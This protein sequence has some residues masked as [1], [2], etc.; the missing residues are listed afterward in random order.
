MKVSNL[1]CVGPEGLTFA[2]DDI[3]CLVGP[4]NTGKSTVLRAYELAAAKA[5]FTEN[6]LCKRAGDSPASVELW[7]HIPAGTPNIAEKWKAPE[8]DLLLVRSKW[9][10]RRE[11]AWKAVRTTWDPEADDWAEDTNA[12]GLD[13]VFTSRLPVP[14]RVGTLQ[15]PEEEHKALLALVLQPVAERLR[16]LQR[17]TESD[18]KR[19]LDAFVTFAEKPVQ[20]EREKIKSLKEDLNRSHSQIFPHLA[21]D[22]DIGL[23]KLEIDLTAQLTK[24]S[25][26][27]F[28][29]WSDEVRWN[30]QGTG[31]QRALFWALLQVRSRL[32]TA[33]ELKVGREKTI[34][35][36]KKKIAKLEK[37]KKAAKKAETKV[38]K[39]EEIRKLQEQLTG[40]EADTSEP[41]TATAPSSLTLPGYMLLV[42]EPEVGLHPAAIRAASRYLYAL[43]EDPAWQVILSSHAPSFIDPLQD[44]TTIV[45]LSR[46]EA[47]PT[48]HTYRAAEVTFSA[49]ERENL[50]ILNRFDS[51]VAEMFF[52]QYPLL[53]EGDTEFASFEWTMNRPAGGWPMAGR[54]L[55]VRARGKQTLVLLIRML[56]HFKVPFSV[57][58]DSDTPYRRDG[59][60]NSAW[61]ANA[62]LVQEIS[63]ARKAGIRVV[64][65]VSIPAFELAHLPVD[66]NKAGHAKFPGERDK[67]WRMLTA[68]AGNPDAA[69]S[70]QNVLEQLVSRDAAE[71][72]FEGNFDKGLSDRVVEWAGKNS[73]GDPRFSQ[74]ES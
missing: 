66:K 67:P 49:E 33:A 46:N 2:L 63:N 18:L 22:L 41:E 55:L 62:A 23:G 20:E 26:V 65:R 53:I 71:E 34:A 58:H 5:A 29:E 59:L 36:L 38:A 17:D 8:G 14:L 15:D 6:D 13:E 19:A 52:G 25:G 56:R 64:H 50:K 11:A 32:Q 21:V 44:H 42:D 37:D 73:P 57:L 28:T 70:V 74:R 51:G 47:N 30:Q 40:Q 45:R 27:R 3:L 4:N 24:N 31:S 10:W 68:L 72:P 1:G 43:A 69:T 39:S 12:A 16:I 54:P 9:E 60:A 35:D 7:V 48:P 61:T